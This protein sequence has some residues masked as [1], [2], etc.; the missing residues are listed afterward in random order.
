MYS[1]M[2]LDEVKFN[3]Y[4]ILLYSTTNFL[5][6]KQFK[7]IYYVFICLHTYLLIKL[8][9]FFILI[10]SYLLKDMRKYIIQYLKNMKAKIGNITF[11][12]LDAKVNIYPYKII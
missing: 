4:S 8:I 2:L 11:R 1:D 9:I 3:Y 5:S 7:Q 12:M 10:P 6:R